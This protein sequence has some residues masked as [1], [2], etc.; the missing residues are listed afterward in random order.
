LIDLQLPANYDLEKALAKYPVDYTES[1]NT[2]LVQELE[3]FNKLLSNI[4]SS[5]QS[6]QKAIKG[7]IAMTPELEALCTALMVSKVI[8][9]FRVLSYTAFLLF[10]LR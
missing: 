5:L 9:L 7:S 4:R 6:L 1:M 2:V 3:R 8:I 10:G